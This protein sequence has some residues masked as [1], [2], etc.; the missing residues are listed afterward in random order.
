M[1]FA[2]VSAP[3]GPI[4]VQEYVRARRGRQRKATTVRIALLY[5]PP[6]MLASPPADGQVDTGDASL[7]P[8]GLLSLAAQARRAGYP[9]KVLNLSTFAWAD[10][11]AA[12]AGL[13]ADVFGLSCF[14]SNRV[15]V[16][17]TAECVRRHHPDAHVVVGGPHV[18]ALPVETLRHWHTVDTVVVGEG[19]RTFLELLGRLEAGAGTSGID[20]AAWRDGEEVRLG[21]PRERIGDLDTLAPVHDE[22]PYNV[23]LTSRGCPGRCT[24]CASGTMWGR[25]LSFHSAGY[26]VDSIE[27][28]LAQL[29]TPAILIKDD[30]FT[31]N[32]GRAMA[33]CREI[34]RRGLSFLWSC[35]TRADVLDEELLREMRLAGC[36]RISLGVESAAPEILKSIR[37]RVTPEQVRQATDL[38]RRFGLRVRYYMIAGN[39]GETPETFRRSVEFLQTA[40]PDE[41]VFSILNV[42]P[43]TEEFEI[44]RRAGRLDAETFFQGDFVEYW[45]PPPEPVLSELLRR[46]CG[47]KTTG[48]A[49]SVEQCRAVLDRLPDLPAALLDLGAAL[50]REGE[51]DPAERCLR[52]A[53][54]LGYPI[55][56]LAE[57][58]L[59]GI[60]GR[61]GDLAGMQKLLR[62][63]TDREHPHPLVVANARAL[64]AWLAAGGPRSGRKLDLAMRHDFHP[65]TPAVQ[66]IAPAPLPPG[67][68]DWA[69]TPADLRAAS[70]A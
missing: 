43:G 50:F 3:S 47:L 62:Q 11:E 10:V 25:R 46:H 60:L 36:Q 54:Q 58:Y 26:V 6:R 65:V 64:D 49:R 30:T 51:L 32:R 53:I 67:Y 18:S 12:V 22:F 14:T 45:V 69:E 5:P 24:F 1:G 61:R 13:S 33:V 16:A 40:R 56:E 7:A 57:N 2:S 63:A 19:E 8:Y 17:A 48:S 52:R 37:K 28:A 70:V 41:Y 23:V 39:R 55:P 42:F 15:G 31:A 35:D 9:V 66:P 27:K 20:G 44:F 34:R 29:P 38:A 21:P 4:W 59:A 68:L